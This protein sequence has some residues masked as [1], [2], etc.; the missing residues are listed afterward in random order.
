[1][2]TE[3]SSV[4]FDQAAKGLNYRIYEHIKL[5]PNY[6]KE[7]VQEIRLRVN[8]PV[9]VYCANRM[10]YI[11]EKGQIVTAI[12]A[13][14]MLIATP[15]DISETFQKICE[16]SVY[17]RQNEIV[18]GFITIQGGHRVGICGTAVYQNGQIC[19][20]K[21]VSSINIRVA[22]QIKGA[23]DEL[24]EKFKNKAQGTLL[25]GAPASGKTTILRD[26]A[27]QLST[28]YNYK[29][30]VI[31][32]RGEL[33]GTCRGVLQNDLGQADVLDGYTKHEGVMQALR[34][35]S[36]EIIICD[37]IGKI[38]DAVAIEGCLNSGVTIIASIHAGSKKSLMKKPQV[39]RLINT[40][41]F[42]D[43]VFLNSRDEPGKVKEICT[44]EEVENVSDNRR[45]FNDCQHIMG[46]RIN[47]SKNTN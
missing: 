23:A 33:A 9:A 8:R 4:R 26:L 24:L 15:K 35:L 22:R 29:V 38:E 28:N 10:Y 14:K 7:Q 20:I 41:A 30:A 6:L 27:R 44:C 11:T 17:S 32:E 46:R 21:D 2:V 36:P 3:K 5:I 37:E 25:C 43:F 13:D 47:F 12:L 16:Y 40:G 18:N 19:N 34:S 45:S 31:D 1:M 39:K 42:N